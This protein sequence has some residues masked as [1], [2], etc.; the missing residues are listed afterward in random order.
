[1]LRSKTK[2]QIASI[3]KPAVIPAVAVQE[4]IDLHNTTFYTQDGKEDGEEIDKV[5]KNQNKVTFRSALHSP[6]IRK[7]FINIKP[8]PQ[9]KE[10]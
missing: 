6:K 2:S 9:Q 7:D 4:I 1:M 3:S 5:E 10:K 8:D